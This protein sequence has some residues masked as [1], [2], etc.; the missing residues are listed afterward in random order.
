MGHTG[1]IMLTTM[2]VGQ[3][4]AMFSV[5]CRWYSWRFSEPFTTLSQIK[6]ESLGELNAC[7]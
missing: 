7:R 1:V 5:I 2:G 6:R 4:V 3:T